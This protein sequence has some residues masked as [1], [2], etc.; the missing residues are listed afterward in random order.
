MMLCYVMILGWDRSDVQ[1]FTPS[2]A[3]QHSLTLA[4]ATND[5]DLAVAGTV[6][7]RP[8]DATLDSPPRRTEYEG[9]ARRIKK[10]AP[11]DDEVTTGREPK[12]APESQI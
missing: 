4:R 12:T 3:R 6:D 8:V 11:G 10:S 5:V 2:E 7:Q 1:Q 9:A